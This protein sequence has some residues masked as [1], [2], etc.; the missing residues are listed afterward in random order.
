MVA[1]LYF[2]AALTI[3][4]CDLHEHDSVDAQLDSHKMFP[5]W[6]LSLIQNLFT[7]GLVIVPGA[8]AIRWIKQTN[9][10]EKISK[11]LS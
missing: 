10:I 3:A 11:L 7:Y 1:W 5:E 9:Y 2:L 4:S 8:L 6:F